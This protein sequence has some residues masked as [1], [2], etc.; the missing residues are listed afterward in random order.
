M[1]IVVRSSST[2]NVRVIFDDTKITEEQLRDRLDEVGL[3]P[4]G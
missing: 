4:I 1:S 2:N 3:A